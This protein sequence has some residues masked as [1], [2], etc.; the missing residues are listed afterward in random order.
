MQGTDEESI[1][2]DLELDYG[3]NE[4]ADPR[5]SDAMYADETQTI[6][7]SMRDHQR[8]IRWMRNLGESVSVI[9][10][11]PYIPGQTPEDFME[12]WLRVQCESGVNYPAAQGARGGMVKMFLDNPDVTGFKRSN[13][14][15]FELVD[16]N[17][18]VKGSV[19]LEDLKRM[20]EMALEMGYQINGLSIPVTGPFTLASEVTLGG[21]P[22]FELDKESREHVVRILA[23]F[24]GDVVAQYDRRFGSSIIRIDE[25]EA[26]G[27][28]SVCN[29]FDSNY[30]AEI[31]DGIWSR[32]NKNIPGIHI[33][34]DIRQAA[35]AIMST[36]T[37]TNRVVLISQDFIPDPAGEYNNMGQ[38]LPSWVN[39]TYAMIGAGIVD[40]GSPVIE[41]PGNKGLVLA[42]EYGR[43][44]KPVD[45]LGLYKQLVELYGRDRIT[46]H[47]GCGFGGFMKG[48]GY[49]PEDTYGRMIAM[50][51]IA[52]K[53]EILWDL[54]N[55]RYDEK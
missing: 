48:V 52:K 54:A 38:I 33:C 35:A 22:I 13:D 32:I 55:G 16:E 26:Q 36:Q 21:F 15:K 39:R 43:T 37:P 29:L 40:S 19:Y 42:D 8:N 41:K 44:I 27:G 47:P 9:G 49:K 30:I 20:M 18:R 17:P 14:G 4:V 53:L 12:E 10:S 11:Y 45:A 34:G 6:K 2:G 5:Y 31:W 25:P 51:I 1:D 7:R 28:S 23:K 3:I 46:V 50:G 24:V